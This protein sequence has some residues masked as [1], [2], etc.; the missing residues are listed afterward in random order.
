MKQKILFVGSH[1]ANKKATLSM[2][3]KVSR[4]LGK[5]FC[6]TLVSDVNNKFLRLCDIVLSVLFRRYHIVHIDLYSGFAQIYAFFS[7]LLA[8]LR[9][10]KVI[11]TLHGGRLP[12]FYQSKPL[13]MKFILNSA[14]TITS[15]S[16]YLVQYFNSEG[17]AVEYIPNFISIDSFKYQVPNVEM[18][19]L[20]WVRAFDKYYNP[21]MALEV[22]KTLRKAH[23]NLIL[24]MVGPD[25]GRLND[26]LAFI[27]Q[28]SL[29]DC[30]NIVGAVPNTELSDYFHSHSVFLNTTSY[31]SFGVAVLEA[32]ASGTPIVSTSVGELPYLWTNKENILLVDENDVKGMAT[33]VNSI[34]ESSTLSYK[35]SQN[36]RDHA[37]SFDE[38]TIK[39]KWINLFNKVGQ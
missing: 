21:I 1:L 36:A 35:L 30:V 37:N 23:S 9:R 2:S 25:K 31:E 11:V 17:F 13:V 33:A 24:T 5:Q 38:T 32:A 3:E 16:K 14:T 7:T 28:N 15:P 19:K 22:L 6:V 4:L 8:K 26:C 29:T 34:L 20:L 39:M 27:K 12:E 10:K 18:Q